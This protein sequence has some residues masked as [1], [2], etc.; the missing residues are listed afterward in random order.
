M[1][2]GHKVVFLPAYTPDLCAKMDSL[3]AEGW[4]F[5]AWLTGWLNSNPSQAQALLRRPTVYGE[6]KHGT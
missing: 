1:K 5:V 2:Y 6:G 3:S 4:E